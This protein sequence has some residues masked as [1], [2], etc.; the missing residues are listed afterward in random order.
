MAWLV[1]QN[2]CNRYLT[3]WRENWQII[4]NERIPDLDLAKVMW[5]EG[6]F[7]CKWRDVNLK[8]L[9]DTHKEKAFSNKTPTLPKSLNMN[10]LVVATSRSTQ[11]R[12]SSFLNKVFVF[13]KI[14]FKFKVMKTLK[15]SSDCHVKT[16]RLSNQENSPALK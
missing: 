14:C 6:T 3:T 2:L 5:L 12:Y 15:K 7:N 16:C 9:K 13:Q 11:K 4:N 8:T 1:A 10:I